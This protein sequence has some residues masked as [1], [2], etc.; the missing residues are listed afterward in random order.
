MGQRA[1]GHTSFSAEQHTVQAG[2]SQA[3]ATE[4]ARRSR[5]CTGAAP[6]AVAL[7][8]HP[9]RR[10]LVQN[11]GGLLLSAMSQNPLANIAGSTACAPSCSNRSPIMFRAQ[12]AQGPLA[13]AD[14]GGAGRRA[15]IA[16]CSWPSCSVDWLNFEKQAQ[17]MHLQ[18]CTARTRHQL[19]LRILLASLVKHCMLS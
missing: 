9:S 7:C 5:A 6:I 13:G 8:T 4:C 18:Y 12:G 10:L 1:V 15:R 17:G 2:D 19:H 16:C 11:A 14:M 3:W